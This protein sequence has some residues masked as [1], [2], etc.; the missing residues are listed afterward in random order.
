MDVIDAVGKNGEYID[1][2]AARLLE[3]VFKPRIVNVLFVRIAS[4]CEFHDR[5]TSRIDRLLGRREE[6]P[7]CCRGLRRR[8]LAVR[9]YVGRSIGTG[10]GLPG[11]HSRPYCAR[12]ETPRG[13]PARAGLAGARL[14]I[15]IRL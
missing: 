14:R 3:S 2:T 4:L 7:R 8:L 10:L 11:D 15:A 12:W 6:G 1:A 13:A 5:L 9:S